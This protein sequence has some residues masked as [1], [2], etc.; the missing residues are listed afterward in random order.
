MV[1]RGYVEKPEVTQDGL[2]GVLEAI[3]REPCFAEDTTFDIA[4]HGFRVSFRLLGLAVVVEVIRPETLQSHVRP[5]SVVPTFEFG[6][7]E[8][9]V[10]KTF[11]ERHASE[12]LVFEG[13][14]DPLSYSNGSVLSYGSETRFDVPLPQQFGKDI[15][16]KDTGPV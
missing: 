13:F 4:G 11:D 12:P 9:Q 1:R 5:P 15:P 2:S 8:R 6:A 10:V 3:G 14:D 16:D 7:Q